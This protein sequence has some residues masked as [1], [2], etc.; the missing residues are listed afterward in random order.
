MTSFAPQSVPMSVFVPHVDASFSWEDIAYYFEQVFEI[1]KLE[2]IEAVPKMNQK[3]GH[4]YHA[5]FLYFSHWNNGYNAQNLRLRMMQ[6]MQTRFYVNERLYWMVCPN[7]SDVFVENLPTPKHMSLTMFVSGKGDLDS[8]IQTFNDMDLGK[9]S[10]THTRLTDETPLNQNLLVY[11]H[12]SCQGS[13]IPWVQIM[14][15][16]AW[17]IV[18]EFDYWYHSKSAHEFQKML[19]S[20]KYVI[21]FPD[22]STRWIVTQYHA[23]PQTDGINPYIWNSPIQEKNIEFSNNRDDEDMLDISE[24]SVG[25]YTSPEQIAL[26]MY[27]ENCSIANIV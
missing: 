18:V 5:C 4:P 1:G 15:P 8:I 21:L 17:K 22:I 26:N 24:D 23:T 20:E 14:N 12:I 9:V 16:H 6:N 11:K 3:D 25:G 19:D 13:D 10:I 7:T 2:R 27:S